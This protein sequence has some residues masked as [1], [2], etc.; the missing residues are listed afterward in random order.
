MKNCIV[1]ALVAV[2]AGCDNK[3]TGPTPPAPSTPA[4]SGFFTL[5]GRVEDS[6]GV[7]LSGARIELATPD[8][9]QTMS[10]G[11]DGEYRFENVRRNTLLRVSKDGFDVVAISLYIVQDQSFNVS[12]PRLLT[13]V[14]GTPVRG[15]VKSPPCDPNWDAQ[16]PCQRVSFIPPVTGVYEL[17]LKWTGSRELD[18]LVDMSNALYWS[19]T[20]GE[21]RAV[22]PG[23][24]GRVREIRIHSYYGPQEF[25]LTASLRQA[26]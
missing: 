20:T 7:G 2:V 21:I 5:S 16:A 22:V 18:L 12:L 13:L 9:I 19:S 4:P 26:P 24:A 25:E 14:P 3:V 1:I 11:A 6:E 15:T 8:S 10:S 23:D 17:V